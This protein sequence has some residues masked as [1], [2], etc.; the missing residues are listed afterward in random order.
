MCLK[1]NS[2]SHSAGTKSIIPCRAHTV[3]QYFKDQEFAEDPPGLPPGDIIITN[4]WD[5]NYTSAKEVAA[6]LKS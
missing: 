1:L 2:K 4:C 3:E 5:Y 6:G